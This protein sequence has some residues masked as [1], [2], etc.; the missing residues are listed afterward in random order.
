MKLMPKPN[1][2]PAVLVIRKYYDDYFLYDISKTKPFQLTK[3]QK[4]DI[5]KRTKANRLKRIETARIEKKK[6]TCNVCK[7]LMT[8]DDRIYNIYDENYYDYIC[9]ICYQKIYESHKEEYIS[10]ILSKRILCINVESTGLDPST[11]EILQVSAIDQ[12]GNILIN[13]YCKPENHI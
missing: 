6:C 3:K 4:A 7:K 10:N 1:V 8:T 9:K 11:D 5:N 12:N 13:T 2:K